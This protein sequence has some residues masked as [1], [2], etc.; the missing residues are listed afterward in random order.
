M[1]S[2]TNSLDVLL[3]HGTYGVEDVQNCKTTLNLLSVLEPVCAYLSDPTFTARLDRWLGVLGEDRFITFMCNGV[4]ARLM[5]DEFDECI[6]R[7]LELLGPAKLCTLLNTPLTP[8]WRCLGE[9]VHFYA[10][11]PYWGQR[12]SNTLASKIPIHQTE[13]VDPQIYLDIAANS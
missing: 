11:V 5:D 8:R 13:L 10:M 1:P 2:P 7:W 12:M 9:F 6:T 4:A 3:V